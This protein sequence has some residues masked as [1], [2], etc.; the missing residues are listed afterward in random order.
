MS[1]QEGNADASLKLP[2][3]NIHKHYPGVLP[4]FNTKSSLP[5]R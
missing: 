3:N 5:L 4:S 2:R 1:V